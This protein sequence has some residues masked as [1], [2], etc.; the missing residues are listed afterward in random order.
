[1]DDAGT[2]LGAAA[3]I[4][5][6]LNE[7]RKLKDSVYLGTFQE[8]Q[9]LAMVHKNFTEINLGPNK[10]ESIANFIE[11][12]KIIGVYNS[13]TECGPRALGNRSILASAFLPTISS[14]LNKRL[15][16]ND[17]MPFAPIVRESDT[18]LIFEK[19]PKGLDTAKYMTV[20]LRVKKIF[21]SQIR[22]V[23]HLDG[24]VRPQVLHW[25]DNESIY[26]ILNQIASQKGIGIVLNTSFNLHE[27]LILDDIQTALNNLESGAIDL[28]FINDKILFSKQ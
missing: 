15:R 12:G 20:T 9:N 25:D 13:R 24:T 28:L 5:E 26:K 10:Y 18:D 4:C 1:M 14:E 27:F 22:S 11:N 7:S 21:E 8:N 3:S 17:F 6:K 23:I 16:R 2:A 19:Y